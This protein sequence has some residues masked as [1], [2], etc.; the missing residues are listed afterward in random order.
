M[1]DLKMHLIKTIRNR[2][3][4]FIDASYFHKITRVK[5]CNRL[6][7]KVCLPFRPTKHCS[8]VVILVEIL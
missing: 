6:C 7:L 1:F 2:E 4:P 8:P 3:E 5:C